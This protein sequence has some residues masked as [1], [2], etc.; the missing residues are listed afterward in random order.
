M[1]PEDL[2]R[3]FATPLQLGGTVELGLPIDDAEWAVIEHVPDE[4]IARWLAPCVPAMTRRARRLW[5]RA[6]EVAPDREALQLAG[7]AHDALV[8]IHPLAAYGMLR[9]GA[10]DALDRRMS[11]RT[12][13]LGQPRDPVSLLRRHAWI[14]AALRVRRLDE[15]V[16]FLFLGSTTTFGR[17]ATPAD[18]PWRVEVDRTEDAVDV[19]EAASGDHARMRLLERLL[20]L[21]PLSLVERLDWLL[22]DP[23][24]TTAGHSAVPEGLSR[25]SLPLGALTPAL[26]HR[27]LAR[28]LVRRFVEA[29]NAAEVLERSL[30][31]AVFSLEPETLRRWL[32][33]AIYVFQHTGP[34]GDDPWTWTALLSALRPHRERLGTPD[35][36]LPRGS[37]RLANERILTRA[38]LA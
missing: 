22:H 18:L 28:W 33:F 30:G 12:A 7:I 32:G 6:P 4:E 38:G 10:L 35:A 8:V 11:R 1:T 31:H 29:P 21:S 15:T 16:D 17:P 20:D 14:E 37:T 19:S 27:P 36:T 9:T 13:T 26:D 2:A 23:S 3:G 25:T 5:A 34:R 24:G